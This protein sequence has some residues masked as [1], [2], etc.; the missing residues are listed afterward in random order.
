MMSYE[1]LD[2]SSNLHIFHFINRYFSLEGELIS[3]ERIIGFQRAILFSGSKNISDGRW[4]KKNLLRIGSLKD[5]IEQWNSGIH[6][7]FQAKSIEIG[8]ISLFWGKDLNCV[9]K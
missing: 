1:G 9:T 2:F 5:Q 4:K 8:L 7:V 6:L 3:M